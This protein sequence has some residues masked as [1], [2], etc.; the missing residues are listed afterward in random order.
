MCI[1]FLHYDLPARVERTPTIVSRP[2]MSIGSNKRQL[3][4]QQKN[5]AI[6]LGGDP[7]HGRA[8]TRLELA[9]HTLREQQQA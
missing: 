5:G 6:T 8:S 3:R 7:Q 9:H 2:I 1:A 4:V